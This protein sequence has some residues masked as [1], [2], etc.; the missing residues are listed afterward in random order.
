MA[1]NSNNPKAEKMV[2]GLPS[3]PV[4]SGPVECLGMTFP[5]DTERRKYAHICYGE[6]RHRRKAM[7]ITMP[8]KRLLRVHQKSQAQ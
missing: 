7:V 8:Q 3:I 4:P 5:S 1:K 6:V 2:I